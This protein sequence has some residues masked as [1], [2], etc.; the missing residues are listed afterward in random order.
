MNIIVRMSTAPVPRI[1]ILRF[2]IIDT[3]QS[4]HPIRKG[5]PHIKKALFGALFL[6]MRKVN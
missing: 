5:V 6:S 4:E 2:S 1:Y 3:L